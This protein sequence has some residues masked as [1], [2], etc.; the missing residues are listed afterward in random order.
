M[1]MLLT[2][3]WAWTEMGPEKGH[4]LDAS[5][6]NDK[7]YV[8]TRV[9]VLQASQSL[10]DWK[11][12][13]RFPPD[14][15]VIGAWASGVWASPPGSLWE[16]TDNNLRLAKSFS[17]SLV[18]DIDV[19]ENGLSASAVRGQEQGIW[20]TQPNG[21]PEA[22]LTQ[23]DPWVVCIHNDQIWA[24]TIDKGLWVQEK[25]G[26]PFI[27][28]TTGS[29]TALDV[30]GGDVYAA[31]ANGGV[32]NT[33][34]NTQVFAIPGGYA[35]SLSNLDSG[36]LFLT[37][38]SPG[39]G[40]APFQFFDGSKVQSL[41]SSKVDQD[42]SHLSPTG[43]WSLGKG[44]ALV[45]TFRRGPL[46]WEGTTQN[47][48]LSLASTNFHATVSG[49]AAIDKWGHL[50]LALMGTGVY[51]WK[52]GTF[53]PHLPKGPVTDS[54]AV[55]RVGDTV[56][57][58]DFDSVRILSASGTWLAMRGV[59][60]RRQRRKNALVDIGR[61]EQEEWWAIDSYGA[62]Y[63]WTEKKWKQCLVSN[64]LRID[65]YGT[66]MLLATRTGYKK[67]HCQQEIPVH[68]AIS[69]T[70]TSRSAGSWVATPKAL[71]FEEKKVESLNGKAIQ[72]LIP[73]EEGVLLAQKDAP[74]L[75]CTDQCRNIAPN[76]SDDLKAMG[77]LPDGTL[78]ALEGRGTLWKDDGTGRSPRK[79]S[80]S[81][82]HRMSNGAYLS[83][84]K[85][86]WMQN[87]QRTQ[88]S[89]ELLRVS[90]SRVW[91]WIVAGLLLLGA[92]IGVAVR[93]N[94]SDEA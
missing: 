64:V 76:F 19:D 41:L 51:V 16:V 13:A 30:I 84:Y 91:I 67:P 5:V 59:P 4:I 8:T 85:E 7:V 47:D 66:N 61:D 15:K 25:R 1:W 2:Q 10:N 79:W 40:A 94:K 54:V 81:T 18:V 56:V 45:G 72:F 90:S 31:Y 70:S 71:Y 49:G 22:F 38:G 23:T 39:L 26:E 20:L 62:L 92:I 63:Q 50:V 36:N 21:T 14:T 43:S 11:R 73:D 83:L 52:E 6:A 77:R 53:S 33:S 82:A 74:I 75:R 46:L 37:V 9:G 88:H 48:N 24:G 3:A 58:L 29:V 57:V 28:H 87:P 35:T 60:D 89:I 44:R 65:G 86:P 34:N 27:Q 68:S 55:K 69:N 80:T 17:Q 78:W 42:K 32:Y 12:D 93:N